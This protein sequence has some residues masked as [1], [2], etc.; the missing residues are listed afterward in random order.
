MATKKETTTKPA[1]D[2][3]KKPK[4][5]AKKAPAKTTA[6]KTK[7]E[8]KKSVVAEAVPDM[9]KGSYIPAV[10]RRKTSIARIRLVKNGK[11]LVTVNGR[12]S[13]E[14]FNTFEYRNQVREPL[15][16][17]GQNE[18]VDVSIKIVGGG[19]RGQ[20]EAIRQGISRALVQLNPTFRKSLK[21]LG[22]LSRDARAKERKKPGLKKARRAPQ[23]SK[24]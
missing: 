12:T 8:P 14:Y 9:K 20:A 13:D 22:Y 24:R 1:K 18:A 16:A 17:V 15:V 7:A 2:E 23:W 19:P 5:A 21:K 3:K 10:G 11:G 4:T 6:K